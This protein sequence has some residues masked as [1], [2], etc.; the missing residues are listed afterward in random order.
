MDKPQAL[1]ASLRGAHECVALGIVGR[2]PYPI[3]DL[4][5]RLLAFGA[6]PDRPLHVFRGNSLVLA[7]RSIGAGARLAVRDDREGFYLV[8]W[9]PHR[10]GGL[11]NG[12]T[13]A[14]RS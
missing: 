1:N 13:E 5:R 7:V 4:C 11:T 6:E 14:I 9:R 12:S 10:E 8:R 2:G 3:F